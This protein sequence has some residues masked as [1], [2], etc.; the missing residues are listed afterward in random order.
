KRRSR[1]KWAYRPLPMAMQSSPATSGSG[2]LIVA[3]EIEAHAFRH[4]C[5][6]QFDVADINV[7]IP[8]FIGKTVPGKIVQVSGCNRVLKKDLRSLAQGLVAYVAIPGAADKFAVNEHNATAFKRCLRLSPELALLGGS[9]F[10][11]EEIGHAPT[12]PQEKYSCK[13]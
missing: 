4:F 2:L 9:M 5:T 13:E 8:S 1:R 10:G 3:I 12:L 6:E 11:A 7:Y